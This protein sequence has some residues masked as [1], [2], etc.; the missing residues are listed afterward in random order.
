MKKA[1]PFILIA[2]FLLAACGSSA[3]YAD[4]PSPDM[5][6][7]DAVTSGGAAPMA[8]GEQFAPIGAPMPT[9]GAGYFAEEAQAPSTANDGSNVAAAQVER[10]VIQNADIAIIVADVDARAKII[11]DMAEQ[12]GGFVVSSNM[13]QSYTNNGTLVPEST[14]VI[15]VPSEKLEE[16]LKQIKTDVVEVQSENRS[17]QDVTAE[18]VDLTSR[19][20]NLEAAEEQLDAI[21]KNATETED[22]VNVFNQLVYYREQ[23]ELVKGQMKYYEQAA[24]LSSITV[25]IIA[26]ETIEP[27]KIAGW[28][29]KGVARDAVQNLIYFYQD[30]ADFLINFVIYTLPVLITLAIPLYLIFLGLRGIYRRVRA[31]RKVEP[32]TPV[33][34]EKEKKKK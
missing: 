27:I 10:M 23:I 15:R 9:A 32:I 3:R 25:R 24:A 33:V 4:V 8:P 11:S 18:Y 16:A 12:M 26:E 7:Y 20:K 34:E 14:I 29:P 5:Y 22:V 31:N 28:E 19:L 17:G 30:F 13:Y 6:D 1:L 21:M 2:A